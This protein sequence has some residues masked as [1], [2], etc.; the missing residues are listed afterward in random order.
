MIFVVYVMKYL[1]HHG[2]GQ[3][4]FVVNVICER[5]FLFGSLIYRHIFG[6]VCSICFVLDWCD[7]DSLPIT[8]QCQLRIIR[9]TG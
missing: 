5:N 8:G 6:Q 3:V 9:S 1:L 2:G 7:Q 4:I